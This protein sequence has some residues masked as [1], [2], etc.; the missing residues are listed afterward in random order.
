[1]VGDLNMTQK[2]LKLGF[3]KVDDKLIKEKMA[4]SLTISLNN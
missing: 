3:N 2:T 1:V 4:L